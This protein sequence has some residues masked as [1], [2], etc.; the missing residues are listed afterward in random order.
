MRERDSQ[1][2]FTIVE[3]LVVIA[4]I[5]TL[6]GMLLP[7]VQS[8]RE[9]AR[10]TSCSNN[11][12]Q[13]IL[14]SHN[15]E[16]SFQRF[17]PGVCADGIDGVTRGIM[18]P[19]R[20]IDR[21]NWIG[22]KVYLLPYIE[23]DNLDK[24]LTAN[25]SV[26]TGDSGFWWDT[27]I[28]NNYSD[29]GTQNIPQFLCPSDGGHLKAT[30]IFI[31]F[32]S[33][34]SPS[35]TGGFWDPSGSSSHLG[36]SNYM[37]CAGVS[38]APEKQSAHPYWSKFEGIFTNRSETSFGEIK[39]GSS[40]TIAFGEQASNTIVGRTK[41]DYS[42]LADGMMGGYGIHSGTSDGAW[43]QFKSKHADVIFIANAD[44]SAHP[45]RT[46]IDTQAWYNLCGCADGRTNNASSF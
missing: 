30:G 9:A 27:A 8:V 23:Q 25:R 2:G 18:P 16:S 7:A 26:R 19:V 39:D 33:R 21:P 5:G 6:V 37:S 42:W 14:A 44:G 13:L 31:G 34:D 32:Y 46:D 15:F 10:R 1:N 35:N 17:P 20:G 22:T 24:R 29:A 41:T 43:Y 4:I 11:I 40:N 3:L 38:G 28:S 45:L 36:R 12:S